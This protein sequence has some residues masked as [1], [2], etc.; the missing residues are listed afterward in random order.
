MND[1]YQP[2]HSLLNINTPKNTL[3]LYNKAKGRQCV[4]QEKGQNQK[5]TNLYIWIFM[6]VRGVECCK[7]IMQGNL[8]DEKSKEEIIFVWSLIELNANV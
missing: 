6:C 7:N 1:L 8:E 5:C 3:F 4:W 2:E